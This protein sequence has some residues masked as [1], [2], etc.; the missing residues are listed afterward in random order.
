MWG[1]AGAPAPR[2][3]GRP[4]TRPPGRSARGTGA[5]VR[6]LGSL[7]G[8]TIVDRSAGYQSVLI[9]VPA[10]PGNRLG[11]AAR[12]THDPG[13]APAQP[14]TGPDGAAARPY[15]AP[16]DDAA[17]RAELA[18]FLRSRRERI[19]PE[20]VGLPRGARRRTPGLRREE[21]A[22]LGR[23][24]SPGTPGWNRPGTSMYRRRSWTRWPVRCCSTAPSAAICSR[25][26]GRSIRCP[27][28]SARA[29]PRALRQ[30]LNSSRRSPR[31]CRTAGSTS[32]PT[33]AR[34]AG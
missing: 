28:G 22:H 24:G 5:S 1:G 20:Q 33:T 27:A 23:S 3:P 12:W 17:R 6:L 19:T 25:W 16:R 11:P 2:S 10:L 8:S 9:L 14:A 29:S 13:H 4:G 30:I 21:V 32:S 15:T 26:R 7:D 34:T 18:A 31:A